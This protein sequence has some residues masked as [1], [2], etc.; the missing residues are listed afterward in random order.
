MAAFASM[1]ARQYRW[2]I[3]VWHVSCLPPPGAER[4]RGRRPRTP[5]RALA[6]QTFLS[7]GRIDPSAFKISSAPGDVTAYVRRNGRGGFRVRLEVP[8]RV[9]G[10]PPGMAWLSGNL[11]GLL[12][13][14]PVEGELTELATTPVLAVYLERE[15]FDR[16]KSAP[17]DLKGSAGL[18]TFARRDTSRAPNTMPLAIPGIGAAPQF[19]MRT[20]N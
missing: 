20:A 4:P 6:I 15:A 17:V 14:I 11:K 8:V 12:G 10:I 19:P 5:E 7:A 3:R 2:R 13:A 16:L 9:E 1:M 18:L